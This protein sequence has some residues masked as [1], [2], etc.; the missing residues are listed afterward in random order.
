MTQEQ[1]IS[2]LEEAA[3][4]YA[5]AD[6]VYGVDGTQQTKWDFLPQVFQKIEYT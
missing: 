5:A 3:V 6:T 2:R 4:L 1:I